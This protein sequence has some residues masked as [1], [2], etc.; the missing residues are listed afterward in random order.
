MC[1]AKQ[2]LVKRS[3]FHLRPR[4]QTLTCTH[5][6][7]HR[8][9]SPLTAS[10]GHWP[11]AEVNHHS[12]KAARPHSEQR[13]GIATVDPAPTDPTGL[14]VSAV[15]LW[16]LRDTLRG[17]CWGDTSNIMPV[18]PAGLWK[19]SLPMALTR[20]SNRSTADQYCLV[21]LPNDFKAL[22]VGV[23]MSPPPTTAPP[24]SSAP[25]C[26]LRRCASCRL[27]FTR[28]RWALCLP[29]ANALPFVVD[30]PPTDSLLLKGGVQRRGTGRAGTNKSE[31][32]DVRWDNS[33]VALEKVKQKNLGGGSGLFIYS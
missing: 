19:S 25:I 3:H 13:G 26:S 14:S 32:W 21:R 8:H 10:P 31:V 11:T 6:H 28:P 29:G 22:K 4:T 12:N 15:D 7:T 18:W 30:T 5:T 23:L 1:P 24:W 33:A 20:R 27:L 17:G 2:P 9:V 16:G